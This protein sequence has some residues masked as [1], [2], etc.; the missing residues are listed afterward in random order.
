MLITSGVASK[1]KKVPVEDNNKSDAEDEKAEE[2]E[3]AESSPVEDA[4]ADT[5]EVVASGT[6]PGSQQQ[7]SSL[8][9][10]WE[11]DK[12]VRFRLYL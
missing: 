4:P 3:K 5:E 1:K 12:K 7:K 11:E 10:E 8:Q 9:Q 2:K 6:L